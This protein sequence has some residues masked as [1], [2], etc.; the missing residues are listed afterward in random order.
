[1][2]SNTMNDELIEQQ[3]TPALTM[4]AFLDE[5]ASAITNDYLFWFVKLVLFPLGYKG[6][7]AEEIKEEIEK[8]YLLSYTEEEIIDA[9]GRCD[10]GK[11][12]EK[13]ITQDNKELYS[14]SSE[15]SKKI[16]ELNKT[17]AIRKYV[18]DYCDKFGIGWWGDEE[19][20][21]FHGN[22]DIPVPDSKDSSDAL[23]AKENSTNDN[24]LPS[25]DEL[26]NLLSRFVYRKFRES[27]SQIDG[28]I[29]ITGHFTL[30]PEDVDAYSVSE[31]RFINNFLSW[32][33][34][35][36]NQ[37]IYD[38]IGRSFDFYSI[39]CHEDIKFDFRNYIFILDANILMRYMKIN[40]EFRYESVA[41]FIKKAREIGVTLVVSAFTK[42]EVEASIDHQS[43]KIKESI[44]KAGRI[45]SPQATGFSVS[46]DFNLDLYKLFYDW[47]RDKKNAK[48][49][50]NLIEKFQTHLYKQ[51]NEIIDEISFDD[52]PSFST[53]ED[54]NYEGV[55][56]VLKSIRKNDYQAKADAN[57]VLLALEY[58]KTK[59]NTYMISSDQAL[60]HWSRETYQA[61]K[62]L[63]EVPSVWL[64][65]LIRYSGR[66]I[67]ENDYKAF[68][69]F[70][71]LSIDPPHVGNI[72]D[73]IKISE[74]VNHMDY[75]DVVK[76]R[77]LEEIGS[78][79][80]RYLNLER[81]DAIKLAHDEV[82]KKERES[83]YKEAEEKYHAQNQQIKDEK[84]S[85]I[86]N[87][88]SALDEEKRARAEEK[89]KSEKLSLVHYVEEW[90]E[91]R[92]NSRA[93]IGK[94]IGRNEKTINVVL[95]IICGVC[96]LAFVAIVFLDLI[97]TDDLA[98]WISLIIAAVMGIGMKL[99]EMIQERNSE[100]NLRIKYEKKAIKKFS[101]GKDYFKKED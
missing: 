79:G 2:Y 5:D 64:S 98:G 28:L 46:S 17:S 1:M 35:E 100:D 57:N 19:A 32:D 40:N 41:Q 42:S 101:L 82:L 43:E 50:K 62:S 9:I 31:Q 93:R 87:L 6:I 61:Q 36:K 91:K 48:Y 12:I 92:V 58:K 86:Q 74:A 77:I 11:E 22:E 34:E 85:E 97:H 84:D 25:R 14:L 16:T 21:S 47:V 18:D 68:C 60:I 80:K 49:S 55:V 75:S 37:M 3:N 66:A 38:L 70:I 71:R 24:E 26:V 67:G 65:A 73:R 15:A 90:I 54:S 53:Y 78:K 23:L 95:G 89:K 20:L 30:K 4:I 39:Q 81:N 10:S 27:L 13:E 72:E 52:H 69:Q 96:I 29:S 44:E 76:D 88:K 33:N 99:L 8:K 56:R 59:P 63:I 83:G 94:F 45:Q 7:T 51:L